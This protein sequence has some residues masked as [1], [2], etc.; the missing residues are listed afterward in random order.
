MFSSVF[1]SA[2]AHI[3]GGKNYPNIEGNVYFK[4]TKD[5]VLMTAKI[6]GLPMS[7]TK[8]TGRF[9]GFHIHERQNLYR[10]CRR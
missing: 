4:E 9:F 5:G 1:Y 10:K 3:K 7:T 8:C 2:K 6:H